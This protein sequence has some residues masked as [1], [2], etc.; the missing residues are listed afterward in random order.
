MISRT[1]LFVIVIIFNLTVLNC[2]ATKVIVRGTLRC[3]G[4]EA[5]GFTASLC[6]GLSTT[7]PIDVKITDENGVFTL[8]GNL[9]DAKQKYRVTLYHNCT[10]NRSRSSEEQIYTKERDYSSS[11]SVTRLTGSNQ[12]ISSTFQSPLPE[13][14]LRRVRQIGNPTPCGKNKTNN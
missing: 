5:Q 1:L 9:T 6:D 12:N 4:T 11:N 7:T 14:E 8:I 2:G 13:S 3:N 10:S